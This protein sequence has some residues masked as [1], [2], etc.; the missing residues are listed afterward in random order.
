VLVVTADAQAASAPGKGLGDVAAKAVYI[1][2]DRLGKG[3]I[4]GSKV[5]DQ[6]LL[7]G[8]KQRDHGVEGGLMLF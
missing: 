6:Q 2:Q 8:M 1:V 4:V 3:C 5:H 7:V